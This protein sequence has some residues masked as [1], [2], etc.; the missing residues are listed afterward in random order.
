VES[1]PGYAVRTARS[2]AVTGYP[3]VPVYEVILSDVEE[4]ATADGHRG[5]AYDGPSE[6]GTTTITAD[7]LCADRGFAPTIVKM[8]VHGCEGK[9]LLGM[10]TVLREHVRYLLLEL[11]DSF[12]LEKY[13]PGID[14][15]RIL[16][17]LEDLGFSIFHVAGQT[18][19]PFLARDEGFTYRP[20]KNDASSDVFYDRSS[21]VIF[22]LVSR[23]PDIAS[24]IGASE[25]DPRFF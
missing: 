13:S 23:S 24:V 12:R 16:R 19:P 10:E 8:D 5:V 21:G 2:C 15:S 7:A 11:H 14:R 18:M 1:D 25:D 4:S 3:E 20:L 22:L 9:V 17:F 6:G